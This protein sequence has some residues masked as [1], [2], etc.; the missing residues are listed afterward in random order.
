[1]HMAKDK[2]STQQEVTVASYNDSC[3]P[4]SSLDDGFHCTKCLG[5]FGGKMLQCLHCD[6]WYCA[7]C[8]GLVAEHFEFMKW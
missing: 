6:I 5:L 3:F 4:L 7:R 2:H 1:M 8:V